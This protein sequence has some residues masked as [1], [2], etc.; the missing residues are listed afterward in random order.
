MRE[1]CCKSNNINYVARATIDKPMPKLVDAKTVKQHLEDSH[2]FFL[3][4]ALPEKY[5]LDGHLPGALNLPH[6]ASDQELRR[7]LPDPAAEIVVYCASRGCSNSSFL[8]RRLES[9]GFQN[10]AVFEDGK[11]GWQQAGYELDRA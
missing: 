1:F 10:V 4:E 2:P 6:E 5:Y 8:A 3:V 11:D 9:L 7:K